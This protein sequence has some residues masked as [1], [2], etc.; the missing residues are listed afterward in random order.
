M[1]NSYAWKLARFEESGYC[2]QCS[3]NKAGQEIDGRKGTKTLCGGCA[4]KH[5]ERNRAGYVPSRKRGRPRKTKTVV[6]VR[7]WRYNFEPAPESEREVDLMLKR[8]ELRARMKPVR[9]TWL[10]IRRQSVC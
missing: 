3:Q 7:D 4:E 1:T 9:V 8:E 2:L 6:L 5:R 10:D